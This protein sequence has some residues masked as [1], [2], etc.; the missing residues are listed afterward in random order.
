MPRSTR[1]ASAV[2]D[3]QIRR[4]TGNDY[5]EDITSGNSVAS[6]G[7]SGDGY[8]I[9]NENAEWIMPDEGCMLWTDNMVIPVGAPNE[10]AALEYMNY[11][12]E[13]KVQAP[14]T[15]YINYVTPVDGVKEIFEKIEGRQGAR[16]GPADLPVRGV[17]G[18]LHR[19]GQSAGRVAARRSRGSSRTLSPARG[20][21]KVRKT[22]R[23]VR[24]S[25]PGHDLADPV[26]RRAHVLHGRDGAPLRLAGQRR[27]RLHLGVVELPRCAR[28]PRRP[29]PPHHL[30][31][32]RGHRCSRS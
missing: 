28:G 7:W 10:A 12:Y 18:G 29:D 4:F 5:T 21:L 3:G 15:A 11:V 6:I 9:S 13:P 23:P 17:H 31:L 26:L 32:G 25:R 1:S 16:E 2:E 30:L 8:L 14:I 27:L 20:A 19:P 22:A 24:P